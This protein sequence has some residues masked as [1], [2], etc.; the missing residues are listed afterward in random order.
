VFKNLLPILL[1]LSFIQH[2]T[3]AQGIDTLWQNNKSISDSAKLELLGGT[4]YDLVFEDTAKSR[5]I[6]E[7][8][9][10]LT[11]GADN[12]YAKINSYRTAGIIY[13]ELEDFN[14]TLENYNQAIKLAKNLKDKEGQ[15]LYGKTLSNY[16]LF[17]HMNGDYETALKI[18]LKADSVLEPFNLYN[19]NINIYSKI[20]DV[21]DHLGQIEKCDFYYKKIFKL[22]EFAKDTLS[23]ITTNLTFALF[24]M[25]QGKYSLA[26][27]KLKKAL[28]L[29]HNYKNPESLYTC[30]FDLGELEKIR[31]NYKKAIEYFHITEQVALS[32]GDKYS[33]GL[34][35][36]KL[37]YLYSLSGKFENAQKI[38]NECIQ[39]CRS[40]G[41]KDILK[42]ALEIAIQIE[43][44]LGNLK[45]ALLY[46][47]EYNIMINENYNLEIR[48]TINF[49]D[50]KYQ[51]EKRESLISNLKIEQKLNLLKISRNKL[52]IILLLVLISLLLVASILIGINFRYKKK[53]IQ[54][55]INLNKQ[56]V[57]ELEKERQIV[58][59]HAVLQGEESERSRLARDL[60]D[61]LGGLLSGIKFNL[62]DI[63]NN[64][65]LTPKTVDQFNGALNLLDNSIH[66]LR[67]VAHNLMPETLIKF[68]LKDAVSDFCSSFDSKSLSITNQFFGEHKRIDQSIEISSFRIIQELIN[69]SLKHSGATQILVQI[70]QDENRLNL[71]VQDNGIGFDPKDIDY[72]KSMGLNSIKSRVT[73]HNGRIEI[74]SG[75]NKGTEI[76]VEFSI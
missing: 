30:Y 43:D 11:P 7:E 22:E 4:C 8:M 16:G 49:L 47:K 10:R 37:G 34:T 29:S 74:I 65:I 54:Q 23:L 60:H 38:I 1:I 6:C 62:S 59:S 44:T 17:Y 24:E 57:I 9:L 28:E 46:N 14:K 25:N 45:Q 27:Q 5:I 64:F 68:G 41:Y 32:W 13:Q 51:A 75:L 26:E 48:K 73:S 67:R 61:G 18:Y 69:N 31:E 36:Q 70:I 42:E 53:I 58:A 52:W 21:Y 71:T 20:S 55:E 66:E 35:L 33:L 50:A 63:K 56:K 15:M 72:R 76:Q 2:R 3:V 39:L 12:I 19:F 40:N